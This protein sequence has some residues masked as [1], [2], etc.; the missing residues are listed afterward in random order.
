MTNSPSSQTTANTH[1]TSMGMEGLIA[2]LGERVN[3]LR[4]GDVFGERALESMF[5]TYVAISSHD[6]RWLMP[7]LYL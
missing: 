5:S 1:N 2:S 4:P 3:Q 7:I 6:D